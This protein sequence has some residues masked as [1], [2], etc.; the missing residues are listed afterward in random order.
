VLA[1]QRGDEEHDERDP[2]LALGDR[3]ATRRP[4]VE[5]VERQRAR[6]R[7][8]HAEP[9]TPDRRDEQNRDQVDDG[10]RNDRR[11]LRQRVHDGR[12]RRHGHRGDDGA[13]PGGAR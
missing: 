8:R 12:A 6:D 11:D 10:E 5:E 2:V 4:D 7:G 9:A 13:E 3:E 1:T